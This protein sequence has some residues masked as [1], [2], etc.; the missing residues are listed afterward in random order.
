MWRTFLLPREKVR[1]QEMLGPNEGHS[2][3]YCLNA[4]E[5]NEVP[6]ATEMYCFPLTE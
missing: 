6:A 5:N 2:A 4:K 1:H 3:N